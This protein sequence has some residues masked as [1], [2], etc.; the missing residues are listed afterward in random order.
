MMPN[1]VTETEFK[2][3]IEPSSGAIQRESFDALTH[4]G[5][6]EPIKE[7]VIQTISKGNVSKAVT[8][9]SPQVVNDVIKATKESI[10]QRATD[11]A[12]QFANDVEDAKEKIK[13]TEAYQWLTSIE[14]VVKNAATIASNGINVNV[15]ADENQTNDIILYGGLAILGLALIK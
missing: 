10:E 5:T 7:R 4:T 6:F 9:Y 12:D 15:K 2:R 8:E 3:A 1:L 13:Q 14:S 11:I